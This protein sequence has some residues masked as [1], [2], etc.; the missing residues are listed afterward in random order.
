MDEKQQSNG[1]GAGARKLIGGAIIGSVIAISV[2]CL[3]RPVAGLQPTTKTNFNTVVKQQA[4]DKV[5]L[6]FAIDNSRSMGDKQALLAAAVPDLI[7]R[8]LSPACINPTDPTVAPTASAKDP[9]TGQPTCADPLK[10]E[11][12]AV[13][14]LH[15]GIVSSSLG[16]G[17]AEQTGGTAICPDTALEPVYTKYNGHNNDKGHLLNRKRPSAPN[18]TGVED[19]VANAVAKDGSGGNFLA[20]LPA[21]DKNNGKA[22]PNVPVEP[23]QTTLETDFKFLVGGTQ[24]YGCGLEA[25]MESWYRFLVQPDPWDSIQIVD[26]PNG[27]PKKATLA[28]VDATLLKQ[29]HD[30]LRPDS[31]V[32]VIMVTDEEDSWSDPLAVGGRGWVTR[33]QQFPGSPTGF[34]PKGTSE[35]TA[36]IDPNSPTT[37]GP[38]SPNCTS[39]GFAGNMA[40]GSPISGDP[41]CQ[42]S[43]GANCAGYY[44]GKEDNLN[45]RYVNDMKRRYGLDPQFPVSRYVNGLKSLKVPNREG[46]H[47]NGGGAYK[48]SNNCT[49][50]LFAASLP[51]DPNGELC[52]LPLGT[53]T[54]DLVYFAIIGGLPWQLL[55]DDKGAFKSALSGDD[56][57]K[58]LGKD[59]EHFDLTGIDPHMIESYLPRIQANAAQIP[60][61]SNPLQP[62]TASDTAD[63]YNGREWDTYKSPL[64][65]D[66]Q[67]ACTFVLPNTKEC[68]DPAN[69]KACDCTGTATDP[70]G[71]P[72]CA[73]GA[74]G[75]SLQVRGKAYPT[76]RELRVAKGLGSQAIVASIC[77]KEPKD[78]KSPDYGYRPAVRAIID[79]LKN[80]L[81]GQCLPQALTQ[82]QTGAVPCLILITLNGGQN[83]DGAC[84]KTKGQL[85]PEPGIL[86]KFNEQRCADAGKDGNGKPVCSNKADANAVAQ[87]LGPVCE[88]NQVVPTAFSN[89]TSCEAGTKD[90]SLGWC[91]VSGTSAGT[92]PQAIKFT[93]GQPPSG[94]KVN[95]QCIE[96]SSGDGG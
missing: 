54:S 59:V 52:T 35:C 13:Y 63:A 90:G 49:N 9:K 19:T 73:A 66:L 88:L 68:S 50:P 36:A 83:Q 76:I 23:D 20:W 17:G 8:L 18:S 57:Q 58:I 7:G 33:A 22:Q 56:W 82:D 64:G 95:L 78:D 31:L 47:P 14:D 42:T 62:P 21:I 96:A 16:G 48:G 28:G 87:V 32:A 5:D 4:I 55:A 15:I 75:K 1:L 3:S 24:E 60:Y 6:L 41:S 92:C 84:D 45:I 80:A 85:Q 91:Y 71:P 77:P 70:T 37:T 61:L 89:G 29:R 74:S 27:G 39:C 46:E 2:G 72:L 81:A 69:A 44:T 94:A 53:R 86:S 93:P 10:L 26:D 38:N 79:R 25:Q 12:P 65:L 30:F 67:Y 40:N 11:F 34:M 43:C 51:T